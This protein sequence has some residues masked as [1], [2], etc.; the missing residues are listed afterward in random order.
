MVASVSL[1]AKQ[2]FC[3]EVSVSLTCVQD[4][5]RQPTTL[6]S[7]G[8]TE[9]LGTSWCQLANIQSEVGRDP[10]AALSSLPVHAS[11]VFLPVAL[12]HT[13][14]RIRSSRSRSKSRRSSIVLRAGSE[15]AL[16]SLVLHHCTYCL[17]PPYTYFLA[18]FTSLTPWLC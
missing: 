8:C 18:K 7:D 14:G 2:G 3:T 5:D 11:W 4:T 17:P 10:A 9:S 1:T 16:L 6:Y 15:A 13:C 12:Q